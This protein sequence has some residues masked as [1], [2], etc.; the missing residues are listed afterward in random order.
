VAEGLSNREIARRL[1][2]TEHAI[3][4][5]VGPKR[6]HRSQLCLPGLEEEPVSACETVVE[7]KQSGGG[8]SDASTPLDVDS[9]SAAAVDS[10]PA[11]IK[12][13]GL[14]CDPHDR[15]FDRCMACAGL[16]DDASP[17]FAQKEAVPFAGVLFAL[18]ALVQSGIFRLGAKHYGEIG[19]AF[20]GL[21]TTLLILLFMALW[22]IKSPEALKEQDPAA[23]GLVLG[24][25]RVPEVKTIRRK[26]NR[27]AILHKAEA[28]GRDLASQ[29]VELH[30]AVMGYLYVDG[31][32]RAYHGKRDIPK[33]HVARMRISMPATTDYWVGDERGDPL[34]VLTADAN[35]GLSQ[36][37][38]GI[39]DEVR[40][41]VGD[42]RV[43]IVFD[44]GGWNLQLFKEIIDRRFHILTYRKGKAPLIDESDF[45][46]HADVIDGRRVSYLLHDQEVLFLDGKLRLRQ[47]TRLAKTG[48]Q[49]QVITSDF[50]T[51]AVEIAVKMFN[52]WRQENFFKYARQE[53]ALDALADYQIE[54]D[55][56]TRTVPNPERKNLSSLIKKK[57]NE[58]KA[59]EQKLG[60]DLAQAESTNKPA[61]EALSAAKAT[62]DND[63]AAAKRELIELR[64]R[65]KVTKTRV[66]IRDLSD[67]AVIK[68][69]TEKKHLTNILK[70]LAF[71]SES[72]LLA[73]IEPQ[74]KRCEDEGRTLLHELFRASADLFPSQD[75][76]I[77][78]LR[79]LSS[80]HRS[81]A[82][83]H[84]C[85][86]LN[87][88]DTCF[89]GTNLVL[90]FRVAPL[91]NPSLAFPGP[92]PDAI[93]TLSDLPDNPHSP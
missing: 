14:E 51:P 92:R 82:I 81:R 7:T 6:G 78:T 19:P 32:V 57:R 20:F 44:R 46:E 22:R 91:P 30:G 59:L 45:I 3:R 71:Q 93:P 55:D 24:L 9:L 35:A 10:R 90:R 87:Q 28:F 27:L 49:T 67:Q 62:I 31:H 15:S 18:P 41:L 89:P 63:L 85:D 60:A 66:E 70:M 73:L 38:P 61:L 88:T 86:A 75:A 79:P 26:L 69:F 77:V 83:A 80:P 1:G 37:L 16:L 54:P 29:R 72:D 84:L 58:I 11:D 43:T 76:L 5:Q 2:V 12:T 47:V 17:L 53:F 48:H 42:R 36:A 25:D 68:L 34:F 21:R 23:L 64:V 52:R 33:A 56:P 39:L 40:D 4:K 74:F 8:L 65:L 13:R 50:D